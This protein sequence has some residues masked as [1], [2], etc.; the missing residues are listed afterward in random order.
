MIPFVT[1]QDFNARIVSGLRR[2]APEADIVSVR[3]AGL[4][5]ALDPEILEWAA[6]E[7]RALLSHDI[8][9][10]LRFADERLRRGDH[11]AGLVKVPQT[12]TIGRA[13]EDLVLILEAANVED[14]RDRTIHLPL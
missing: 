2:R 11:H 8:S 3:D 12:L 1:D 6:H 4:D 13:I 9:T 14:L 10:M 5:R 7:E